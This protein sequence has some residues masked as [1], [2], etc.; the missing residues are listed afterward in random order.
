MDV[1][2]R[3][4]KGPEHTGMSRLRLVSNVMGAESRSE[5]VRIVVLMI[6]ADH[7]V[8]GIRF[9]T[10]IGGRNHESIWWFSATVGQ[11]I[12]VL[13][14]WRFES[15]IEGPGNLEKDWSR[16]RKPATLISLTYINLLGIVSLSEF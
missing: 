13:E 9:Y 12:G 5:S 8:G 7:I 16:S 2:K 10:Y 4:E 15:F 6:G 1:W 11:E 14:I 3:S